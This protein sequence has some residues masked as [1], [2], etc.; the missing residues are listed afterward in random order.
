[1]LRKRR[2][3]CKIAMGWNI[4]ISIW[5]IHCNYMPGAL[6]V[7]KWY[8][9]L[10]GIWMKCILAPIA[11]PGFILAI[12]CQNY[13][14]KNERIT[15]QAPNYIQAVYCNSHWIYFDLYNFELVIIY[16]GRHIVKG[17]YHSILAAFYTSLDTCIGLVKTQDQVAEL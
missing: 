12:C 2:K 10:T 17:R 13:T 9:L 1:M 16:T 15:W 14:Y 3:N 7:Y 8:P 11:L 6:V 4:D 5:S